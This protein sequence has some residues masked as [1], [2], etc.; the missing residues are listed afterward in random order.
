MNVAT[1]VVGSWYQCQEGH[2]FEVVAIDRDDHTIEVQHFDGTLEEFDDEGWIAMMPLE[3]DAPED[4]SGS[5]D[6]EPE[7]HDDDAMTPLPAWLGTS[8]LDRDEVSGFSEVP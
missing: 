4:W 3:T 2:I 8:H 7:D 5:L 1:P 6:I